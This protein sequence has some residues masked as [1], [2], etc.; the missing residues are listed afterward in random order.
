MPIYKGTNEVTS[1][2][3]TKGTTEIENGYKGTDPFYVNLITIEFTAISGQGLTYTLPAT[4]TGNAG[5]AYPSTTFT[6]AGTAGQRLN[7][8]S[9]AMTNLP[10][11][12][13]AAVTGGTNTSTLTVTITGTFPASGVSPITSV[14]SGISIINTYLADFLLVG[15]GGTAGGGY[16]SGGG[17]AGGLRTSYGTVNGGGQALDSQLTLTPNTVYTIT[18]GAAGGDSEIDGSDISVV[19]AT[20]GGGGGSSTANSVAGGS[21]GSYGY[22]GGSGGDSFYSAGGGGG[23]GGA[24]SAPGWRGGGCAGAPLSNSIT[25]TAVDYAA[26]GVGYTGNYTNCGATSS[27]FGAGGNAQGGTGGGGGFILRVPTASYSGNVTNENSTGTD[28]TDTWIKWLASGT[29]TG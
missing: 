9:F 1:G 6:I 22:G 15:G 3:L 26:G 23:A 14:V 10:A 7:T 5:A 24:G 12:L 18:I 11:T 27:T 17:G 13:S 2:K 4:Q 20:G 25:G 8:G 16:V 29:Y 21:A 28:G 19:T